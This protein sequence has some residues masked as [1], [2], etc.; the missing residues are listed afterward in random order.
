[1]RYARCCE[2][3]CDSYVEVACRIRQFSCRILQLTRHRSL[4]QLS[5][6]SA[7]VGSLQGD[8]DLDLPVGGFFTLQPKPKLTATEKT[9]G[10]RAGFELADLIAVGDAIP[11]PKPRQVIEEVVDAV[12]QWP[13]FAAEAGVAP[14]RSAAIAKTYRLLG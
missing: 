11:L 4:P 1:M 10:K 3:R 8:R 6:L 13:E 7:A 14:K 9:A 12:R 5:F 2:R